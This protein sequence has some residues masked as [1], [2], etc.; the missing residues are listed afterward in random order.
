MTAR[1]TRRVVVAALALTFCV[2]IARSHPRQ[3]GDAGDYY[4]MA[5]NMAVHKRAKEIDIESMIA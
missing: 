4:A 1:T 2:L 3:V 5:L